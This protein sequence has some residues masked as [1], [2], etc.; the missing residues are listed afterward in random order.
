MLFSREY[1]YNGA[2]QR[3]K[4]GA[5]KIMLSDWTALQGGFQYQVGKTYSLD[6]PLRLCNSGFHYCEHPI[7]CLRYYGCVSENK[8]AQVKIHGEVVRTGMMDLYRENKCATNVIEI[9]K[10]IN[11]KDWLELCTV[12]VMILLNGRKYTEQTYV[13][14]ILEKKLVYYQHP[15]GSFLP[16]YNL[17]LSEHKGDLI[18]TCYSRIPDC[19]PS[20]YRVEE[21]HLDQTLLAGSEVGWENV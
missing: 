1:I 8:F 18:R 10:E 17:F 14:G 21:Y 12:T 3:E 6:G 9:Y 5:Y 4:D 19:F 20:R 2:I 13:K 7:D 11:F 16:A 15:S